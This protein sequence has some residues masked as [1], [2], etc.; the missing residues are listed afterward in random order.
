MRDLRFDP[1]GIKVKPGTTVTW[2]NKDQVAHN[3]SQIRS[4]FLSDVIPSGGA[5]TFTFTARGTY[6]YQCIFHHPSMNG[7]VIVAEG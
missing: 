7:V 2:V 1:Q 4:A 5:F 6:R 3:V